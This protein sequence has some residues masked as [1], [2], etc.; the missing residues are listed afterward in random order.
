MSIRLLILLRAALRT[1]RARRA[2][3]GLALCRL[4]RLR[5]DRGGRNPET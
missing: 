3:G 1:F 2:F 4:F 5:K